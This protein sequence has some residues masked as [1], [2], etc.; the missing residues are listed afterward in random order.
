MSSGVLFANGAGTRGSRCACLMRRQAGS[1]GRICRMARRRLFGFEERIAAAVC[2]AIEPNLRAAEIARVKARDVAELNAYE[3]TLRALPDAM[4]LDPARARRRS[5]CSNAPS[6]LRRRCAAAGARG[7]VSR[8]VRRTPLHRLTRPGKGDGA[9]ARRRAIRL[10]SG[11]PLALTVLSGV[12]TFLHDLA[13]ADALVELALRLDPALPGHGAA[14]A[15]SA[16]IGERPRR[17]S[18]ASSLRSISRQAIR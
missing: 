10:H 13:T 11:D 15:G 2:R 5:K 8:P 12:Y 6:S 17:L 7:V 4:A 1:S 18:N 9:N 14:V 3:L 16:A